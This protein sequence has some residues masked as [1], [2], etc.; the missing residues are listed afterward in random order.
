[1]NRK[2]LVPI[3]NGTE[4]MEAVILI[5][6]LRRAGIEVIVAGEKKQAT[7]SRKVKLVPDKLLSEIDSGESY[8]AIVIPGGIGG[9]DNLSVNSHL[10]KIVENHKNK[11][12]IISAICAAPL[13]LKKYG[14][15]RENNKITSHP[16]VKDSLQEFEYVEENVV[17]DN[18]LVTSRG[19]GSAFEFALKLIEMLVDKE[20]AIKIAGNIVLKHG[21]GI[22]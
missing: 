9:T 1:M 20:T 2:V 12:C 21:I 16:S 8:D 22:S 4:E 19:A 13:V 17:V 14:I 6:M 10:R 18:N 3:A 7:C 5:D 15:L 11:N